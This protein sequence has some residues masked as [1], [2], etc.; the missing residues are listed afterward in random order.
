MSGEAET[1]VFGIVSGNEQE[2]GTVGKCPGTASVAG[3]LDDQARWHSHPENESVDVGEVMRNGKVGTMIVAEPSR[4]RQC[5][6]GQSS[7]T[8][9]GTEER[10][11]ALIYSVDI[12]FL[13]FSAINS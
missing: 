7:V 4:R 10:A 8:S 13:I 2:P 11:S 6:A 12:V 3:R 5:V 1:T 9:S